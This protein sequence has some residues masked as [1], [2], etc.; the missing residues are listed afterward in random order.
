MIYAI[1]TWTWRKGLS[2]IELYNEPE[3]EGCWDAPRFV[4]QTIIR[5][6]HHP[7]VLTRWIP[8]FP[9]RPQCACA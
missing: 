2:T 7:H 5:H 9:C 4:E 3:L 6:M 1:A 8:P